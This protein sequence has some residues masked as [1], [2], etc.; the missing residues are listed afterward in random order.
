LRYK[1][2]GKVLAVATLFRDRESLAAEAMME[3]AIRRAAP[4]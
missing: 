4:A 1:K 3:Q 2:N